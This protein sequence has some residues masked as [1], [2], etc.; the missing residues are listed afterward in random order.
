MVAVKTPFRRL[1]DLFEPVTYNHSIFHIWQKYCTIWISNDSFSV[2][3]IYIFFFCL[4]P[5]NL[6]ESWTICYSGRTNVSHVL[7]L[8]LRGCP[9]TPAILFIC[10]GYIYILGW[11][12]KKPQ[13]SERTRDVEIHKEMAETKSL[14]NI[15]ITKTYNKI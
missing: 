13:I 2:L 4:I 3:Y 14:S 7:N 15:R 6:L 1:R 9:T 5:Y 8:T 11:K 10:K 12:C